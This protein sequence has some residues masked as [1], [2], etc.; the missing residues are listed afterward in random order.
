MSTVIGTHCSEGE[1]REIKAHLSVRILSEMEAAMIINKNF[2][3]EASR[4]E[5]HTDAIVADYSKK[6]L[7][8]VPVWTPT[9]IYTRKALY[10]SAESNYIRFD[11]CGKQYELVN[12]DLVFYVD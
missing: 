2:G 12:G 9:K 11:V 10:A 3:F 8:G 4:V 1:Y 6:E 7:N 5:V